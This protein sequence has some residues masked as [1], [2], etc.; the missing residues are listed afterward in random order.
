MGALETKTFPEG[1]ITARV[2]KHTWTYREGKLVRGNF[3]GV[4][5]YEGAPL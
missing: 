4:T 5:L 2:E 1:T 3:R